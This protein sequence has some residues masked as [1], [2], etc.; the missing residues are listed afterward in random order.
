MKFQITILIDYH[1]NY[2]DKYDIKINKIKLNET[3]LITYDEIMKI[4]KLHFE[5][6]INIID[7]KIKDVSIDIGREESFGE[8]SCYF[9]K[10]HYLFD[11]TQLHSCDTI[12]NDSMFISGASK[13]TKEFISDR[14]FI[15][16]KQNVNEIMEE[17]AN[18]LEISPSTPNITMKSYRTSIS[19]ISNI[20]D[21][22]A[23]SND[24]SFRKILIESRLNHSPEC[25]V[26][27]SVSSSIK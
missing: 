4:A 25:A 19:G 2:R 26:M 16:S 6:C 22:F 23:S 7:W 21:F 15:S 9:G 27:T 18:I 20:D 12:D 8:I 10:M 11:D 13:D 17:S 5:I 3:N 14:I 1:T 24:A